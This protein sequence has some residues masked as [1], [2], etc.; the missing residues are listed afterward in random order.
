MESHLQDLISET[1]G[2][3][4]HF[5][6]EHWYPVRGGVPT[7]ISYG[8]GNQEDAAFTKRK[9]SR[10]LARWWHTQTDDDYQAAPSSWKL[11]EA[12]MQRFT[13][14]GKAERIFKS[15]T[16]LSQPPRIQLTSSEWRQLIENQDLEDQFS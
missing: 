15:L 13:V 11:A 6:V 14:E 7:Q 10:R 4:R 5:L 12:K 9:A 3:P 2:R 8:L 16:A 1:C